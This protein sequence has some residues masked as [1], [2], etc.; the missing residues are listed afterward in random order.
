M[1]W[2]TR[3]GRLT[4]ALSQLWGRLFFTH[5]CVLAPTALKN[6]RDLFVSLKNRED[7]RSHVLQP[8]NRSAPLMK[9]VTTYNCII[10]GDIGSGALIYL[11]STSSFEERVFCCWHFLFFTFWNKKQEKKTL[12]AKNRWDQTS[13]ESEFLH[14][15]W[16]WSSGWP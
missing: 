3:H 6:R 11:L 4:E 1:R 13:V 16:L 12:P 8:L 7:V 10:Y 9:P 2:M 5:L 15:M 14:T